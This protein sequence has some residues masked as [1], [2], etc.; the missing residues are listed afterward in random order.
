MLNALK[1]LRQHNMTHNDIKPANI[2]FRDGKWKLTD[3]GMI[4][5][6][7]DRSNLFAAQGGTEF[8]L[9]LYNCLILQAFILTNYVLI[10]HF[11]TSS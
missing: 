1:Y 6:A 2:L 10:I 4:S 3:F 5:P 8:V 11:S 7:A 9:I